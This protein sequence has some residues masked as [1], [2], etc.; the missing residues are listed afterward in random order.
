M[1]EFII[2]TGSPISIMPRDEK[3]KRSTEIPK[4]NKQIPRREQKRTKVAGGIPVNVEY[5][6]NQQKLEILITERT[7][8]TPLLRMDCMKKF[9]LTMGKTQLRK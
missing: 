5:E 9:K 7:D 3:L 1:N 8:M 4:K 6:N 2:D